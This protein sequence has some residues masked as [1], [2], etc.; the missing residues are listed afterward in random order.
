MR[1]A[2]GHWVLI[3]NDTQE[4]RNSLAVSL[5]TDEGKTW[6]WTRHL[7]KHPTGSYHYPAIIQAS[8]GRIHAIYSYFVDGGKTMKHVAF[9][10]DWISNAE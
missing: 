10:E 4:G 1:L 8:D 6:G 2:N 9:D 7:E 3:Y 5:S